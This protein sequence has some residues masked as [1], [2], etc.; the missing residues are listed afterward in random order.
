MIVNKFR[1]K[2]NVPIRNFVTLLF[3]ISFALVFFIES[4]RALAC[5]CSR[6]LPTASQNINLKIKSTSSK[7][8][9]SGNTMICNFVKVKAIKGIV[10]SKQ[11][12][13]SK[14]FFSSNINAS[15]ESLLYKRS[16]T[17]IS[18]YNDCGITQPLP[19]YLQTLSI[20]C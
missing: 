14:H 5:F 20:R 11:A 8:F 10:S 16:V 1:K 18:F 19:V 12:F 2:A 13:D 15:T 4:S 7:D 6:C 9:F 3:I 17:N